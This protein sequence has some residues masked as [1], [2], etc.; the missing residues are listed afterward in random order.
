MLVAAEHREKLS[1]YCL[2]R[3]VTQEVAVNEG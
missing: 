1:T 2:V 3:R